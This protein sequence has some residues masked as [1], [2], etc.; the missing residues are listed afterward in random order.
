MSDKHDFQNEV[1]LLAM[2][3]VLTRLLAHVYENLSPAEFDRLIQSYWTGLST[4]PIP[5]RPAVEADL[6]AAEIRDEVD[7]LLKSAREVRGQ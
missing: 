7:R 2:E 3:I 1:R 5:G 4:Q 6:I